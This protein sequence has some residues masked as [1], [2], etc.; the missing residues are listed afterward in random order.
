MNSETF[1]GTS[2]A[3]R[4]SPVA[5][6]CLQPRFGYQRSRPGGSVMQAFFWTEDSVA[7][8]KP[9][10]GR[11]DA[12]GFEQ[13]AA[14]SLIFSQRETPGVRSVYGGRSSASAGVRCA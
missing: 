13:G 14:P 5:D 4:R 2:V 10:V 1:V 8:I 9:C 11:V 3:D 6:A 12:R 7:A